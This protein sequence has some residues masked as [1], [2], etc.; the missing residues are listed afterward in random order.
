MS[1]ARPPPA[2]GCN[3]A[4][5]GEPECRPPL[6]DRHDLD[7]DTTLIAADTNIAIYVDFLA[8]NVTA[9]L[10]R[11]RKPGIPRPSAVSWSVRGTPVL[12]ILGLVSV[13][14]MLT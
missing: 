14:V 4:R 5:P 7:H 3:G 13:L 2:D 10:L 12:P 8:V 6:G 11:W 1:W 9:I